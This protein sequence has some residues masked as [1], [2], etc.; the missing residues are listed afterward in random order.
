M[1]AMPVEALEVED[2]HDRAWL[3]LE[4]R[5][6]AHQGEINAAMAAHVAMIGEHL[7]AGY[8]T[9]H[10]GVVSP[11][12]FLTWK[13]GLTPHE[14]NR[15]LEIAVGLKDLPLIRKAFSEGRLSLQ[16]V[17]ILVSIAE[18][19][20]EARLLEKALGL[21]GA[22]LARFASHYRKALRTEGDTAHRERVL[23][24]GHRGDGSWTINGGMSSATGALIDKALEAALSELMERDDRGL[25]DSADDPFGAR[26]ADC[27][28][29]IAESFMAGGDGIR[30]NHERHLVTLHVD[31]E[32]LLKGE[33]VAKIDGGG[34]TGIDTVKELLAG[35]CSLVEMIHHDANILTVSDRRRANA[36]LKRAI[37][38]RDQCCAFPGCA[39][40]AYL[41]NH[42]YKWV[43]EGGT[44]EL[45]NEWPFCWTHHR[46][47]HDRLVTIEKTASGELLFRDHFGQIIERGPIT[48]S[49]AGIASVNRERGVE[50][51]PGTCL[52]GWGGEEGNLA[53]VVDLALRDRYRVLKEAG[54]IELDQSDDDWVPPEPH[55]ED[56]T[57]SERDGPDP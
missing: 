13:L 1:F 25:D 9:R 23:T 7:E 6:T 45:M 41:E 44:T 54:A 21:S 53:Y 26:L 38:A 15:M 34:I 56:A 49:G 2:E 47:F 27:L 11:Q 17:G 50:V 14:A 52:P 5:M 29:H 51:T 43:S 24:T 30:K 57:P 12:A 4:D 40:T 16:Q 32:D 28:S 8:W 55:D 48:A 3:E 10:D 39:R 20:I 18:P 36:A 22:Q 19:E 46:L 37:A 35:G 33:G 31:L 42:H